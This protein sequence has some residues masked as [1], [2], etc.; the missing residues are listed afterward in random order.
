[1]TVI[2]IIGVGLFILIMGG[3]FM[4]MEFALYVPGLGKSEPLLGKILDF[5]EA[6]LKK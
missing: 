1:M 6:F 2:Q 5:L 3:F 4:I